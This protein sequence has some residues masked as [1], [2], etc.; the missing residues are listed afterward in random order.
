MTHEPEKVP[1]SEGY[2]T[3]MYGGAGANAVDPATTAASRAEAYLGDGTSEEE[4]VRA[5]RARSR[6]RTVILWGSRVAA[7]VV[8]FGLW[9]LLT[10]KSVGVIDPFFWSRPSSIVTQIKNW[11]DHGT[12]F[13]SIWLQ[14]WVTMKEALLGFLFGVLAGVVVGIGLGQF[15]FLSDVLNPY[16]KVVNAVPRIVLGALFTVVF[17]IG[18]TSKVVTAAVLVF[19]GVFFNAYQGVREVDRNLLANARVLGANRW[20]TNRHVVLP[21]AATWIIASLHVAFGFAIIGAIVGELLGSTAGLGLVIQTS[22]NTFQPAGVF[23]GMA[24]I[25]AMALVAEFLI[26][27]LEKRVLGWRPPSQSAAAGT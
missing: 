2:N 17:G 18:T 25:A 12:Q 11:F 9:Q 3:L 27:A 13:G 7:F 16:I 8:I 14:I 5:D 21:S 23:G 24:L 1:F 10:A 4:I 6:R 15:R 26:A 22:M 20:Q 19:F